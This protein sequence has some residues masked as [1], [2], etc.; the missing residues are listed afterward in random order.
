VALALENSR[1]V[2]EA[3]K[4]ALRNQMIA[5]FSSYVR[6]TLDVDAVIQTAATELRKVFDLK[7]AEIFIGASTTKQTDES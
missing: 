5:S 4:N 3:Q 7:E 1:L 2:D 6:E